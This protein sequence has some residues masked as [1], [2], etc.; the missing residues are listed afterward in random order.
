MTFESD[1]Y[2]WMASAFFSKNNA[3][4]MVGS[5][6]GPICITGKPGEPGKDGSSFEFIY[7]LTRDTT[8]KPNY[9]TTLADK[10][11]L[12]D[13]AESGDDSSHYATWNGQKWYDRAQAIDS[14]NNKAC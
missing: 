6:E 2:T 10:K 11:R 7:A 13:E 1:K 5:W 14:T 8:S 4:A 12:F 3:G 9:P